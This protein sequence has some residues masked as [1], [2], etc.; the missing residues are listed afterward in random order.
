MK[1]KVKLRVLLKRLKAAADKMEQV[2]HSAGMPDYAA[3]NT[4][5]QIRRLRID[6]PLKRRARKWTRK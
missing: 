4:R 6:R 5:R 3:Y 1:R 2:A